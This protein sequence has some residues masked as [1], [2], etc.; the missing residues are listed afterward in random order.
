ML[1]FLSNDDIDATPMYVPVVSFQLSYLWWE[2]F[3]YSSPFRKKEK[4][5]Q[6]EIFDY[7][8]TIFQSQQ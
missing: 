6:S 2:H 5:V 1:L 7:F 3:S 4:S 8:L